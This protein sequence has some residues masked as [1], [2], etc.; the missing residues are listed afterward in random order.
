MVELIFFYE[1][2][3][4]KVVAGNH[5]LLLLGTSLHASR[6]LSLESFQMGPTTYEL[7]RRN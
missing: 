5:Q 6:S 1:K 3:E 7:C 2:Y 4:C